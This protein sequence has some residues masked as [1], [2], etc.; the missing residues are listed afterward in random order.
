[1]FH[2]HLSWWCHQIETFLHHWPF[3][4]GIHRPPVNSPH[5]GQW[6]VALM[7]SLIC[8]RTYGWANHRYAGDLRCHHTHYEVTVM[9]TEYL[10]HGMSHVDAD[11]HVEKWYLPSSYF[12]LKPKY[13]LN[14][15]I[16][17]CS[18]SA[19]PVFWLLLWVS[20]GCAWPITRQVT[21]VAWPVVGW[22]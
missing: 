17:D 19:G 16:W 7:F 12:I 5:K 2:P 20:S 18:T 15:V 6:S 9:V 21:S 14:N 1:M 4:R 11:P 8:T 22:A 3:V 13:M 10:T